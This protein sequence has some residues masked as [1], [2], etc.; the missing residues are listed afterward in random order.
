MSTEERIVGERIVD[1]ISYFELSSL[2]G[3]ETLFVK[4]MEFR[5]GNWKSVMKDLYDNLKTELYS[6]QLQKNKNE[7]QEEFI[8]A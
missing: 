6:D 4:A 3:Y 5:K 7:K 2:D 8:Y 1:E